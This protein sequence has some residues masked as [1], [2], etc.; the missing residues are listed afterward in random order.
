MA[1]GFLNDGQRRPHGN[2]REEGG[3]PGGPARVGS[4]EPDVHE[5]M[6]RADFQSDIG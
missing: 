1:G 2:I 3:R 6:I 4:L 5:R